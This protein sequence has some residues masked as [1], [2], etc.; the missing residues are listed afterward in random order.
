MVF[1]NTKLLTFLSYFFLVLTQ[2]YLPASTSS[3][4]SISGSVNVI[5]GEYTEVSTDISVPGPKPLTIER[6]FFG[7][8][9]GNPND[10]LAWHFNHP[11]IL[12][13]NVS[14][15]PTTI[16][17]ATFEYINDSN[18]R[19]KEVKVTNTSGDKIYTSAKFEY[20]SN[21][22]ESVCEVSTSDG[23]ELCYCYKEEAV[24]RGTPGL[25]ISSVIDTM[26]NQTFYSYRQHP[27]ERKDLIQKIEYPDGGYLETEYYDGK[28]NNVGGTLVTVDDPIRDFRIGRIK[29]QKAPL[30]QDGSSVITQCFFY[31]KGS[32]DVIHS[33]GQ[34][35][36][37]HYNHDQ[38]LTSIDTYNEGA[39]YKREKFYWS[40][41]IGNKKKQHLVSKTLEDGS[42][43]TVLCQ[44]YDYDEHGLLIKERSYGNISGTTSESLHLSENGIPVNSICECAEWSYAYE[45]YGEEKA[46]TR[47][48]R[49]KEPSG[50]VTCYRYEGDTLRVHSLLVG[51]E[52]NIHI[53]QFNLYNEDGLL[54]ETITDDGSSELFEDIGGITERHSVKY[55]LREMQ[56]AIGM[57]ECIEELYYEFE[58]GE[59][60]P[61][62]HTTYQYSDLNKVIQ[63]D[64]YD[65]E[66]NYTY[67]IYQNFDLLGRKTHQSETSGNETFWNYDTNGNITHELVKECDG[68]NISTHKI[69]DKARRLIKMVTIKNGEEDNLTSYRYNEMNHKIADIDNYGNETHYQYDQLGRLT[70]VTY[71]AVMK[72]DES[73]DHPEE[74]F[75]YNVFDQPTKKVDPNGYVTNI[76]YNIYRKPLKIIHPDKTKEEF[77][78]YQDGSIKKKVDKLGFTTLYHRDYQSRVIKEEKFSPTGQ[79]LSSLN[80]FYNGFHLIKTTQ[81]D[82]TEISYRYNSKGQQVSIIKSNTDGLSRTDIEYDQLG[83]ILAKKVWFGDAPNDY[84]KFITMRDA[85]NNVIET[86]V[87]DANG[88]VLRQEIFEHDKEKLIDKKSFPNI[89]CEKV[90][91]EREVTNTKGITI[92]TSYDAL[93][94]AISVIRKNSQGFILSRIKMIYDLAGNK[95]KEIHSFENEKESK[96]FTLSWKYGPGGRLESI[97]EAEGSR[98]Q[99]TTQYYYNDHGQIETI[100]KPDR[101]ALTHEYD[102]SGN[103]TRFYSSD[104]TVDYQYFYD[105]NGNVYQTLDRVNN[106]I[107]QIEYNQSGMI[108]HETLA[109]GL[110]MSYAYDKMGR[111]TSY[112]L[113]D[114]SSVDYQYDAFNL[115]KITRKDSKRREQYHHTFTGYDLSGKL[116]SENLANDCG[117]IHYQYNKEGHR[118]YTYSPW[119]EETIEREIDN[120]SQSKQLFKVTTRD[121]L[122]KLESQFQHDANSRL[123]Q[124]SGLTTNNYT[125]DSF[126]NRTSR[127]N[128]IMTTNAVNALTHDGDYHYVYDTNGNLIEKI[129]E[130]ESFSF[131]YDA[132][133][134]MTS[135]VIDNDLK[136]LYTYDSQGRRLLKIVQEYSPEGNWK[137]R[138][139]TKFIFV[140]NNEIAQTDHLG[141]ITEHR[142][143]NTSKKS[144]IGATTAIEVNNRTYAAINDYRGNITCLVDIATAEVMECYRYTA[145]GEEVVIG[146]DQKIKTPD[147]AI[148]SWRFSS[149]RYENETKFVF[150]G[151]RY[152]SPK[153]GRWITNDPLGYLDGINRYCYV[154]N[155]PLENNDLYGL[156]TCSEILNS[157]TSFFDN[158]LNVIMDFG[159]KASSFIQA[160]TRFLKEI[161]PDITSTLEE[162][163]GKGFLTL[164][165]YYSH[166]LESGV[167]GQGEV[168][169]KVRITLLN[170]ISNIRSYYRES[171]EMIN[172]THGGVNIHY[173]FRPTSGW[174]GDM[175]MA[176]LIKCGYVSSY[177]NELASTWREMIQEMGGIDGGG[178]IIHYCHSLGGTDTAIA[179]SLLTPEERK[180]IKVI[181]FGSATMITD[182]VGFS[183]VI[184]FVSIRD[185]VC[186]LDPV[187]YIKGIMDA[188]SNI[189]FIGSF[190]GIPFIDHSLEM[191]TYAETITKLGHVFLQMYAYGGGLI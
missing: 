30:G 106:L 38:R 143:L 25:M 146:G 111:C 189:S 51:D 82:G 101:V 177:A 118:Q 52:E 173:I 187:G 168:S 154:H 100:I 104:A 95:V 45:Q 40:D 6:Y 151:K 175:L 182:S 77:E 141:S 2:H 158:V 163:F 190:L 170:G 135:V 180:M 132:L 131:K 70:S 115:Q 33:N 91:H 48:V 165:G 27:N 90:S 169:D 16:D 162:Y 23:R 79:I 68:S 71:P 49:K 144:D 84:S 64:I 142:I 126:G 103:I 99:R 147:K 8:E 188:E 46:S 10:G 186:L 5:T 62:K 167:Y 119:W 74:S 88:T 138:E 174:C 85:A 19:I 35:T 120:K 60:L 125:Y 130:E 92:Q 66:N 148:C 124:E 53:R 57:P 11:G 39:L 140:N 122:G 171:L 22:D 179:A 123:I 133:N 80:S 110:N 129:N 20:S 65:A 181:S 116:L 63:K 83:N 15:I 176:F 127:N 94:R 14:E 164:V 31:N 34:K 157:I 43:Q 3:P 128:E 108:T 161:Q 113:P 114:N 50:K 13:E 17:D 58:T 155:N 72:E 37:Y 44:T 184:N 55:H 7:I 67:S 112:T 121:A 137:T 69:Y 9:S 183:D 134:R 28:H 4:T 56:P 102:E 12:S 24:T 136:I 61:V 96:Q 149:K 78:Y 29:L 172:S 93:G 152:Y 59:Y 86:R 21:G 89:N 139:T 150:F 32:T 87:E 153:M 47:L 97:T 73:F 191:D 18:S 107:S 145:F 81:L 98:E 36:T 76:T 160:K 117:N 178:T 75:E 26:G 109:N 156:I 1:K 41:Q 42:G 159:S 166:P 105:A 185:G 54:I